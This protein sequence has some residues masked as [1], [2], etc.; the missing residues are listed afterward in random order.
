MD[1]K[2]GLEMSVPG[3]E[4]CTNETPMH[5]LFEVELMTKQIAGSSTDINQS[6]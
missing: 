3:R 5:Y 2:I 1:D 6:D 4:R